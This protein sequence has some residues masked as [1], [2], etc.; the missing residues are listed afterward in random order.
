MKIIIYRKQ[1][2]DLRHVRFGS[3]RVIRAPHTT[4]IYA[5]VQIRNAHKYYTIVE[6]TYK[7]FTVNHTGNPPLLSGNSLFLSHKRTKKKKRM[8]KEKK[9]TP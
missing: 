3:A 1:P 4:E 7:Y 9:N 5:Y 2:H 6:Y 8:K